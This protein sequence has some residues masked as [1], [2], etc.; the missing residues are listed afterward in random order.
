[1]TARHPAIVVLA[2]CVFGMAVVA[3]APMREGRWEITM[4]IQMPD[5]PM[6]MPPFKTTQCITGDDLKDPGRVLPKGGPKETGKCEVADYRVAGNKVTWKITC[7][8]GSEAI[9][10]EGELTSTGDAYE[11]RMKMSMGADELTMKVSGKR[12]GDCTK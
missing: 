3:Q 9:R 1:M 4:Q 7:T 5:M 10:G 11:G 12:V 2:F 8:R 6:A